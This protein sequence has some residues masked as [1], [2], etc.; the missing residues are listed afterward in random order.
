MFAGEFVRSLSHIDRFELIFAPELEKFF[1]DTKRGSHVV[2]W[3]RFSLRKFLQNWL[4]MFPWF[5]FF[6]CQV[7]VDRFVFR[8]LLHLELVYFVS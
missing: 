3:S 8:R 1:C 2:D 4:Q 7:C 6:F 5:Q